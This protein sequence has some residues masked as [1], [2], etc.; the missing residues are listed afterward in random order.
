MKDNLVVIGAALLLLIPIVGIVYMVRV[1][2]PEV[3]SAPLYLEWDQ[4]D[5]AWPIQY[6]LSID[7]KPERQVFVSTTDGKAF[8]MSIA[9]LPSGRHSFALRAC[10]KAGCSETTR[11]E[12]LIP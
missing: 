2:V 9:D 3:K 12:L 5:N 7:G 1:R 6:F 8:R 10:N 11:Q 4:A